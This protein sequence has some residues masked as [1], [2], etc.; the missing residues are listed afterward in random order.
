MFGKI[1]SRLMSG[2]AASAVAALALSFAGQAGAQTYNEQPGYDRPANDQPSYDQRDRD[3]NDSTRVGDLV[4]T[5]DYR[6]NRADNGIPTQRVYA[7]RV[8]YFDDLDLNTAWGVHELHARV[9]RAAA[10]ACNQLDNEYPMGLVPIDSSDGDCKARAV[11]HA[12]A[13]APIGDA[14]DADYHGY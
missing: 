4:V 13:D 3:A 8:V 11:R 14:A 12:M 5:P 6:P 10:D 1:S 7:S 9:V 2:C